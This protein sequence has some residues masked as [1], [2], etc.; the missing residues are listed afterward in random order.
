MTKGSLKG[1]SFEREICKELSFWWTEDER[2]DVFW[3]TSGS[4]GRATERL[5]K[6]K[7]TSNSYGDMMAIDPIGQPF[8]DFCFVEIKR[9]YTKDVSVLEF[10]DKNKGTP[11]LLDWWKEAADK[12]SK[13]KQKEILIIFK[14]DRH[15]KCIMFSNQFF[16]GI[17]DHYGDIFDGCYIRIMKGD[18]DATVVPYQD[19]LDLVNPDL[20]TMI[21]R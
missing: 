6:G 8:I 9:G 7:L 16:G 18:F 19:F 21:K 10:V 2:D 15:K 20:F 1:F 12:I 14:R 3:R 17:K 5:K 4:G 13:T 11:I